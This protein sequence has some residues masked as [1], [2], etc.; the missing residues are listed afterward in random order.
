MSSEGKSH[1]TVMANLKFTAR[2]E[3]AGDCEKV[4]AFSN[5]T[6]G[7]RTMAER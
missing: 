1:V 4:T 2:K 5:S 6:S 7:V 3:V